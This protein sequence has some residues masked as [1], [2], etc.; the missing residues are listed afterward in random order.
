MTSTEYL[1]A[2]LKPQIEVLTKTLFEV[3]E[4]CLRKLGNFLPHAAILTESGEVKLVGAAPDTD[5]DRTSSV[6]VLPLL[7]DG[8]RLQAKQLPL[9]AIAIAENVTI[10]VEGKRPT[11]AIKVLFEH[12]RGL[13]V[14]LYLP[15]EK[16]FFKGYV[17]GSTFSLRA[18]PEV[19]A[20]RNAA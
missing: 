14:A 1:Y 8:L 12:K 4:T 7:H 5:D 16:K 15:F 3:S 20:W 6:E 2:E 18:N 17:F 19:D 11:K 13:T 10:T 9:T